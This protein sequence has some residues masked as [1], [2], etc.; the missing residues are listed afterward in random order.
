[1]V[2]SEGTMIS[3]G[4][5]RARVLIVDDE[6]NNRALVRGYLDAEYEVHEAVNGAHALGLLARTAVDLVLLD[7]MMPRMRGFDICRLIKQ[8]TEDGPYQPV[9]LLTAPGVQEDRNHGFGV[10]AER[11]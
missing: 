7:V 1:M 10:G 2:E 4:V 11:S 3:A 6:P 9:I 5:D 8:T